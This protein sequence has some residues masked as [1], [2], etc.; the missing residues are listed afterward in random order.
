M[1]PLH[2]RIHNRCWNWVS[3]SLTDTLPE[4][5]DSP[6]SDA[7]SSISSSMPWARAATIHAHPNASATRFRRLKAVREVVETV[8]PV[9]GRSY[10][11]KIQS[12]GPEWLS[13]PETAAIAS[14]GDPI[15]WPGILLGTP[16]SFSPT[17][18]RYLATALWL[19]RQGF[20]SDHCHIVEIGVGFGGLA[21]F[22]ALVSGAH[23]TLVDLPQVESLASRM[24]HDLGL[25][26]FCTPSSTARPDHAAC[27]ISNYAFT[28][29]SATVQDEYLEK[30]IKHCPRG[31]IISNAS[32]FDGT[33]EGRSDQQIVNR[34]A[35]AGIHAEISAVCDLFSPADKLCQVSLIHWQS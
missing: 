16:T 17:S 7:G 13:S 14:W 32:F 1:N 29:L 28:E 9:D 24:L 26:N 23:T 3:A 15:R 11:K 10:A 18:L 5:S 30:W 25:G 8:G 33:I 34:L 2:H 35:E 6:A 4:S 27:F 12:W 22:N 19:K 20:I 21:A 31:V